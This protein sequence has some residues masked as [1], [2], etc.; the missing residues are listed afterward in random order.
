MR[1]SICF[2][3]LMVSFERLA[4]KPAENPSVIEGSPYHLYGRSLASAPWR[5][6]WSGVQFLPAGLIYACHGDL[7]RPFLVQVVGVSFPS[8][9]G[10]YG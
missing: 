5:R 10:Q 1:A 7:V 2:A 6:F 3:R 9:G 4:K 8:T